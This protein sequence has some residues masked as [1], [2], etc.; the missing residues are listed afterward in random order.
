MTDT[1]TILQQLSSQIPQNTFLISKEQFQSLQETHGKSAE[2]LRRLICIVTLRE[3]ISPISHFAAS[4]VVEGESGNLYI[5]ANIE[6]WGADLNNSIHAEQCGIINALN[7]GEKSIISITTCP[8]PC[9]HCRQFLREV[10]GAEALRVISCSKPIGEL[11]IN[12]T[13]L[14]I[15]PHSFGPPDLGSEAYIL[16]QN[17]KTFKFETPLPDHYSSEIKKAF[18]FA[19]QKIQYSHSPSSESW[20]SVVLLAGGEFFNGLYV[21]NAAYNP[22]MSPFQSS[23]ISL[24]TSGKSFADITAAVIIEQATA[25]VQHLDNASR[26]LRLIAPS[27]TFYS[28]NV[29]C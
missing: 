17:K 29:L 5:G 1:H 19:L 7:R 16:H 20:A 2:E 8:M 18:E 9:G 25:P 4:A 21:E 12:D 11:I 6:F 3:T 23:I 13:L 27:A 22:S 28:H 14:N 26:I 10:N 15:L 24:V